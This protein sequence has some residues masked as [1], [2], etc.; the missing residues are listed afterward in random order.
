MAKNGIKIKQEVY[1][2]KDDKRIGYCSL[3]VY[4]N[5]AYI[6]VNVHKDDKALFNRACRRMGYVIG[7]T[8]TTAVIPRKEQY[9][10]D[11]DTDALAFEGGT[12]I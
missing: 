8:D 5:G 4:V 10:G 9:F 7:S 1:T 12:K 11:T 3:L 2:D 6:R